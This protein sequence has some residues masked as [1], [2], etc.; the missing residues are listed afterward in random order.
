[1]TGFCDPGGIRQVRHQQH[2]DQISANS[3]LQPH[4]F[5]I[6]NG[7]DFFTN[8]IRR[9]RLRSDLYNLP[10]PRN[11]ST[12]T[13]SRAVD[14]IFSSYVLSAEHHRKNHPPARSANCPR[15]FRDQSRFV[16]FAEPNPRRSETW[17]TNF[18]QETM[19]P[20]VRRQEQS[21]LDRLSCSRQFQIGLY[22]QVARRDFLQ[23][24]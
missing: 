3:L 17:T 5:I 7:N 1:M 10:Y 9:E 18:H 13:S 19:Y 8:S 20:Y 15:S 24:T 12:S 11:R 4:G 14:F 21:C 23:S 22:K 6:N 2:P 16:R